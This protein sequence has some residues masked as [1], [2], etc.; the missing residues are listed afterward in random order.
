[1]DNRQ[2]TEELCSIVKKIKTDAAITENTALIGD[3]VLDSLEFMN[4][5]VKVEE[6]YSLQ[7]RDSEISTL[8]LGM[9]KNM[10]THICS[11]IK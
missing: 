1:M 2:I 7:I 5:I 10:A 9:I 8:Q 6:A 4:Y 11:K 3:A